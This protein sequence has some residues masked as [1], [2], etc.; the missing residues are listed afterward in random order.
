M[1]QKNLNADLTNP[2]VYHSI[3]DNFED[4]VYDEIK[5][6]DNPDE[7]DHL[8]YSRAGSSFKPHYHRMNDMMNITKDEKEVKESNN[9]ESN[10]LDAPGRSLM[11]SKASYS[12][13]D[14]NS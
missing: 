5:A 13:G 2:N 12:S 1:L 14:S 3:D 7:Y 6:K 8:D 9:A 11:D 10:N 4:H